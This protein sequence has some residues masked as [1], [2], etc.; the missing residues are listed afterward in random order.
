MKGRILSVLDQL[1][2]DPSHSYYL[3]VL[4]DTLGKDQEWISNSASRIKTMMLHDYSRISVETIDRFFQGILRNFAR[5]SGLVPSFQLELDNQ[6]V[7]ADFARDVFKR[8]LTDPPLKEWLTDWITERM[9]EGEK[10]QKLEKEL[11]STGFELLKEEILTLILADNSEALTEDKIRKV[12]NQARLI[13]R[14]FR[15]TADSIRQ[16]TRDHLSRTGCTPADFQYG[17]GGPAGFLYKLDID[18]EPNSRATNCLDDPSKWIVKNNPRKAEL[19]ANVYPELNRL[20]HDALDHFNR[21]RTDYLSAKAVNRNLFALWFSSYLIRYLREDSKNRNQILLTLTQPMIQTIIRDNPSPFI[22]EKTGIYFKNYLIDEF[23]DTSDLQWKNFSPLIENS[24]AEGGLSMVVG[25]AKQSLYRWR[26]SNWKLIHHKAAEEMKRFG[27]SITPLT[28]NQRSRKSIIGFNN[29]LFSALSSISEVYHDAK[30]DEG[31]KADLTGLVEMHLIN[32]K[33]EE[34]SWREQIQER[35]PLIVEDLLQNKGYRQEDILFLVRMNRD[36]DLISEI[37]TRYR[38][39][40][41]DKEMAPWSFVSA[42]VFR[43]ESSG[44]V[45]IILLIFRYI[46]TKSYYYLDLLNWELQRRLFPGE[47]PPP[48]NEGTAKSDLA[49]R[50]DILTD[51]DPLSVLDLVVPAFRLDQDQDDLQ[52]LFQFRDQVKA[53]CAG[54]SGHV[55]G[56]LDWWEVTG[57]KKMLV[58]ENQA[59]AMRIMT[60]HKAKGLSSPVVIIPFCNWSFDH[61]AQRGPWI[62]VPTAGTP[63]SSVSM[64]PVRYSSSLERTCFA[65]NYLTEK[66]EAALD[67][68]NLLYVAFTRATDVLIAFCPYGA[69]QKTVAD[70]VFSSLEIQPGQE[71]YRIG[72]P[73]FRNPDS[74]MAPEHIGIG[75]TGFSVFRHKAEITPAEEED[76]TTVRYGRVIHRILESV[77]HIDDIEA[78]VSRLLAGGEILPGDLSKVRKSL[79]PILQMPEISDWFGG[80]WEVRN[81]PVILVPDS[82]ERRPDRVMIRGNETVVLDYKTGL[83][84]SSHRKQLEGYRKTL[85]RMG[86]DNVR[87]FLLYLDPPE[88][89]EVKSQEDFFLP[90]PLDPEA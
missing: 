21:S 62:W 86:Y 45:Q 42:D 40:N 32:A 23:Q 38:S 22:F 76:F 57:S 7:L 89:V 13:M 75:V 88:L 43:I 20:M 84:E 82:G 90:F 17:S 11:I 72:D 30:Q 26:N 9:E 18:K 6:K 85:E 34:K 2:K 54:S 37:L 44:V 77:N 59:A 39:K 4:R 50:L 14:Q 64:I 83:A 67:N 12:K 19:E 10:W 35:L 70:A 48:D 60:I 53:F 15:E 24:L 49:G 16:R 73:D 36:A 1:H 61:S 29:H 56:F 78:A 25:D 51:Y 28:K 79:S 65:E 8:V 33:N 74:A 3:P 63:F 27:T 80:T 58:T 46:S 68:L 71:I 5:E 87:G 69:T 55:A 66:R 41:P 31:L 52:Y 81:E 47:I